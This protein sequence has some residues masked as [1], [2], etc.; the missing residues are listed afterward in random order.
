MQESLKE[1]LPLPQLLLTAD[2]DTDE[3]AATCGCDVD[4]NNDH[5]APIARSRW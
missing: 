4:D 2:T 3:G 5:A 1:S